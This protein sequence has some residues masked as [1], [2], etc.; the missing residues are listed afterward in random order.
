MHH[1][2]LS[3]VLLTLSLVVGACANTPPAAPEPVSLHLIRQ[4][5]QMLGGSRTLGGMWIT[6]QGQLAE[7]MSQVEQRAQ[8]PSEPTPLPEVDFAEDGILA[9]WMGEKPT[10]GFS[11]GLSGDQAEIEEQTALVPVQ[12]LEPEEGAVTPQ[13]ITNP[14][15]IVRLGQGSYNRVSVVDQNG[16]VRA[17][18]EVGEE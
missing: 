4:G 6:D 13:V 14:Y 1:L 15:L 11:L 2:H 7:L 3:I 16:V 17:S 5:Q 10:G 9:V 18:L 12:W 8:L